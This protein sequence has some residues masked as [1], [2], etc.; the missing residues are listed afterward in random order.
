MSKILIALSLLSVSSL[1]ASA[2][3]AAES[4]DPHRQARDMIAPSIVYTV[5]P[6]GAMG[7]LIDAE[8]LIDPQARA[9]RMIRAEWPA[10]PAGG[11]G[12]LHADFG[13]SDPHERA[14]HFIGGGHD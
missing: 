12:M 3:A 1:L 11:I 10:L 13:R 5:T 2:P 14:R 8:A 9:Y 4:I 6:R 7:R